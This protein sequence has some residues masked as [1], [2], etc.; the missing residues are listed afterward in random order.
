M[1]EFFK[2]ETAQ[3]LENGTPAQAMLNYD[4]P[5]GHD[6]FAKPSLELFY[7]EYGWAITPDHIA[8]TNGS[9]CLFYLL[10]AGEYATGN[11]KKCCSRLA[12]EYIG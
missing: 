11:R 12:P 1:V 9:D 8:L 5:Q 7:K 6:G 10:L 3:Q 4:G 2:S